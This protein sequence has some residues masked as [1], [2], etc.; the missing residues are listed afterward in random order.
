V[1]KFKLTKEGKLQQESRVPADFADD[2]YDAV[3]MLRFFPSGRC[4]LYKKG[5]DKIY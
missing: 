2:I 1:I 3:F 4:F 5:A